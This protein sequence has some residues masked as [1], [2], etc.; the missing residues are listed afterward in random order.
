MESVFSQMKVVAPKVQGLLAGFERDNSAGVRLLAIAV[1]T[2]FPSAAHLE[3]L[4]ERLNPEAEKPFVAYH[5]A[6]ALLDAVVDLPAE[7][8]AALADAVTKARDLALR[9]KSDPD[10]L[11][12]L[13]QAERELRL[14]CKGA[15]A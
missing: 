7:N 3:W 13:E 1:L 8:C 4:A 12:V 11:N 6:V 5:A 15:S 9:L 2:I 10:R 14:K